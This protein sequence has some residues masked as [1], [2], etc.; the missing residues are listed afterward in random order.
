MLLESSYVGQ[1][2]IRVDARARERHTREDRRSSGF[3]AFYQLY[4]GV[5]SV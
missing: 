3:T 4:G 5:I 1:Y 2:T